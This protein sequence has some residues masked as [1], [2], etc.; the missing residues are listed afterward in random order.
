MEVDVFDNK[1]VF[2]SHIKLAINLCE[3][4]REFNGGFK[5]KRVEFR[6]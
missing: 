4:K 5:W 3:N 6:K 1:V 2:L